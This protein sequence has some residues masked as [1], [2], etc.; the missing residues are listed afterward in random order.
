LECRRTQALSVAGWGGCGG[1]RAL[2]AR[3]DDTGTVQRAGTSAVAGVRSTYLKNQRPFGAESCG[4]VKS[5][6]TVREELSIPLEFGTARAKILPW[7]SPRCP[8]L[9]PSIL[10]C[11]QKSS[12]IC[13]SR[14]RSSSSTSRASPRTR[15][16]KVQIAPPQY[17]R[18]FA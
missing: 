11:C 4:S 1:G 17:S 13:A 10:R 3:L 14:G 15:E 2:L 8:D 12:R 16:R 6:C 7:S 18:T 5:V 9:P